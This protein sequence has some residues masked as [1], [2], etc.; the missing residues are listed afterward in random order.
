MASNLT[1]LVETALPALSG[2]AVTYNAAKNIYLSSGYTSAA[3]NTYFQGI[4]LSDRII[5]NYDFGQ[6]YAYL[7]LN[8][9]RIY[10]FDGR[11]KKLIASRSYCCKGHSEQFAKSECISM[12]Q[13]YMKGQIKM[14]NASIT[15]SQIQDFSEKLIVDT[16]NNKKILA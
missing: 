6:G 4:R 7:F 5:I 12:I 15:E 16:L 13:E 10:G 9:I 3:G 14:L 8:G 2:S 1:I 11:D